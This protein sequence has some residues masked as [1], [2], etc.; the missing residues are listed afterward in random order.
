MTPQ[1]L[2]DDV[3]LRFEVM[4]LSESLQTSILKQALSTYQS[5]VGA[6]AVLK[7]E[8]ATPVSLPAGFSD[9]AVCVDAEGR[10]H[11]VVVT[12]TTVAVTTFSKSVAPYS[13]TYFLDMRGF[14]LATDSLPRNSIMLLSDYLYVLLAIPNTQRAREAM[15]IT[16]IQMELPDDNELNSRKTLLEQTMDE[17]AAIIPMVTV[18]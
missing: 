11:D 3:L 13:L 4:Y 5:I 12:D 8:N 9:V 1:E 18:Y 15:T 17:T 7:L 6:T 14:D 2:L 10:W 16:G